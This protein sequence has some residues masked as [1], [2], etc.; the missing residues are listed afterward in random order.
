MDPLNYGLGSPR[1]IGM[2][3][4][5]R[6]E[7]FD[8]DPGVRS[9]GGALPHLQTPKRGETVHTYLCPKSKTA[10]AQG[11]FGLHVGE[12]VSHNYNG[13]NV[14]GE[15]IAVEQ[16]KNQ[17]A[18]IWTVLF[19]DGHTLRCGKRKLRQLL[20]NA[21][22]VQEKK[23]IDHILVS[24]RWRSSVTQCRTRWGPSVHRSISGKRSDH[25]LLECT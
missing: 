6:E 13:T 21:K 11:D 9:A 16:S 1:M 25:A 2:L 24:N 18:G 10:C 3:Q 14:K 19:Q 15:V 12:H 7:T 17:D 20:L 4:P 8:Q 22:P 23:Q 5:K